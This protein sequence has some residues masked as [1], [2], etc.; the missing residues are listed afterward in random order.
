MLGL[1]SNTS[2][3]QQGKYQK[4]EGKVSSL[5]INSTWVHSTQLVV[6][7]ENFCSDSTNE[8]DEEAK[9]GILSN[10]VVLRGI[11]IS[12]ERDGLCG[13]SG[14]KKMWVPILVISLASSVNSGTEFNFS[15]LQI[16]YL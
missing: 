10:N 2:G 14:V 7:P 1:F 12:E 6:V 9:G 16:S 4:A 15:E 3:L 5:S 11:W 13:S 8:P